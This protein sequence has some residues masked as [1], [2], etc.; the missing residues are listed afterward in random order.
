MGPA[1]SASFR[2]AIYDRKLASR[3]NSSGWRAL[4]AIAVSWVVGDL[5]KD[6][7]LL[8]PG[9]DIRQVLR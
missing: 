8:P 1:I 9:Y 2:T 4:L 5:V 6:L 7:Y 3:D